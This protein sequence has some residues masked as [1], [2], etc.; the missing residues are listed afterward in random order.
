VAKQTVKELP[1][2]GEGFPELPTLP[3]GTTLLVF[4]SPLKKVEKECVLAILTTIAVRNGGW[5]PICASELITPL[6]GQ[7]EALPAV[8]P[9]NIINSLWEMAGDG[10]LKIVHLEGDGKDYIIPTP[11]L[12]QMLNKSQIHYV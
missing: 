12:V 1:Q 6:K 11:E 10:L 9:Q 4:A 7:V 8:H 5:K 3:E 2:L